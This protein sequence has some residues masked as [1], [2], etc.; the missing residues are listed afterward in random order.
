[1]KNTDV[2]R[3]K[4]IGKIFKTNQ[5]GD[6]LVV[7]Y[8]D[9]KNVIIKFQDGTVVPCRSGDLLNGEVRNPMQPEFRGVGFIGIGQYNFK[10]RAG[11]KW[12][13]MMQRCY[14]KKYLAKKPTYIGCSVEHSWHNLQNFAEWYEKLKY[15]EPNWELDKDLLIRGNKIYSEE[16]CVMLPREINS[17][18]NIHTLSK[19]SGLPAGVT[20]IN[21]KG[22]FRAQCHVGG[23]Q[24]RSRVSTSIDYCFQW[25]REKKLEELAKLAEYWKEHLDPRAYEAILKFEVTPY[26]IE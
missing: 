12:A 18:I 7:D 22:K 16:T 10:S 19:K 20:T 8:V 4:Y 9:Y 5:C 2:V 26:V 24:E 17:A 3:E 21:S 13:T 11:L 25:Y 14:D 6:V 23:K 15:N 1:M